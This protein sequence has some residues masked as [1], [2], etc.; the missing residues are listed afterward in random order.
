MSGPL[1]EADDATPLSH[2]EREG[3]IPSHVTLRGEL[4]ELEQ[5]DIL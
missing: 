3:P 1:D 4:N 5:Q 2:E